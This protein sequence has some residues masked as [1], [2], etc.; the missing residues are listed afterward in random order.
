MVP[1]SIL[2]KL[3]TYEVEY[4]Q[5]MYIFEATIKKVPDI[6]GAYIEFLYDVE[7]EIK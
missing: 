1:L 2:V 3:E 6:D 7:Q 5:K 4:K